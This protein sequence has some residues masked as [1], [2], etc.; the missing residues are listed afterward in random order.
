M[1]EKDHTTGCPANLAGFFMPECKKCREH[2][3]QDDGAMI[4][5][6]VLH[7]ENTAIEK[8]TKTLYL[9]P[10]QAVNSPAPALPD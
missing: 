1:I 4:Y 6:N 3:F 10:F 7:A 9:K 8:T 2:F 5:S